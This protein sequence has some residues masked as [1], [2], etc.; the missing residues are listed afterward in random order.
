[1]SKLF[2]FDSVYAPYKVKICRLDRTV[3][4]FFK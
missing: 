1:M 3:C 4:V 2:D